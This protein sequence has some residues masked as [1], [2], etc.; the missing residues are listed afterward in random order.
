MFRLTLLPAEDGDCLLL[1]YGSE[2][3]QF[4]ILVDGGRTSA[5]ETARPLLEAIRRRGERI[6][7]L[8]LTHIDADHIEGL[9]PFI[10]DQRIP[11]EVAEVWYNGFD[12]L[13]ALELFGP[14]QGDAFTD[15]LHRRGWPWNTAFSRGPIVLPDGK[16]MEVA[17]PGGLAIS[18]LSP[19][20]SALARLRAH[21]M[22]FRR[23]DDRNEEEQIVPPEL[24]TYGPKLETTPG[25]VGALAGAATSQDRTVPNGSSIAFIAEFEGRRLLLAADAHPADLVRS[26]R[27][28]NATAPQT[29]HLAKISHHGSKANTT[30]QLINEMNAR[31]FAISTSGARN[32]HP[33]PEAIARLIWGRPP[34]V[35]LHFNYR[36]E[37]TEVWDGETMKASFG[38][39]CFYGD[40]GTISVDV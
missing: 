7:L 22:E 10:T 40:D 6:D 12:Q 3:K 5:Y 34:V 30:T 23:L 25:N 24:E 28:L 26:L 13:S 27:H 36:S 4:H 31:R 39:V 17:G 1:D 8:V 15:A 18:L 29:I 2:D 19:T 9:L 16:P 11:V 21:W 14:E 37:Y 32:K 20:T 35:E 38:H 33:N